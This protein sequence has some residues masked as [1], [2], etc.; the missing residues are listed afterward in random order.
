MDSSLKTLGIIA[1]NNALPV[2]CAKGAR[3]AGVEKIFAVCFKGE[4]DKSIEGFVDECLWLDVGKL[5]KLISFFKKNNVGSVVMLGQLNPRHTVS[6]LLK[7]DLRMTSMLLKI[8]NRKADTILGAIV[9]EIESDG[10]KVLDSTTFIKHLMAPSGVLGRIKP[11][12]D[13]MNDIDFGYKL[14][15]DIG[16]VDIGQTVVVKKLSVVAVEAMEGS[17]A[18]ITRGCSITGGGAVV[19]KMSKP[20]QDMRF[21][22][23][24]M[25][26]KTMDNLAAGKAAAV[27]VEA[28]KTILLDR[29]EFLRRADAA[30][31]SVVGVGD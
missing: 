24:V 9:G 1:G 21:D 7:F 19:V 13:V 6:S 23:P 20:R 27:A 18:A 8:P 17:D 4:T 26:L 15:K 30:K 22:V 2:E 12:R 3:Q 16:R 31:I 10:I 29:E 14:A 25:G 11:S 5:G 28:G